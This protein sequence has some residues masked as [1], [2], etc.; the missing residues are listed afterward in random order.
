M[1]YLKLL[2][3]YEEVV[4]K[5]LGVITKDHGARVFAKVRIADVFQLKELVFQMICLRL[6]L[7]H[8][9]ILL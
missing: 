3:K 9:L 7:K 5:R 6:G 4:Y 8:I 2:N 1:C